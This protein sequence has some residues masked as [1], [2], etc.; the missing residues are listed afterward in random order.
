MADTTYTVNEASI[1]APVLRVVECFTM[2]DALA[3]AWAADT[4]EERDYFISIWS[5][6]FTASFERPRCCP[7]APLHLVAEEPST[8]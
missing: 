1:P 4:A 2:F 8:N 7:T 3:K 5:E 6:M